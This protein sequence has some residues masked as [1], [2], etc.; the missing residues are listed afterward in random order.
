MYALIKDNE[1]VGTSNINEGLEEG[2]TTIEYD[3]SIIGVL[4]L[5]KGS[6]RAKTKKELKADESNQAEVDAWNDLRGKRN[7]LLRETEMAGKG[8]PD[9]PFTDK[10]LAYRQALRDLPAKTS[11][12]KKVVWPTLI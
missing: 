11:D 2:I 10:E 5:D 8:F 3:D 9:R 4:V 7:G 1:L 12:L 6:I